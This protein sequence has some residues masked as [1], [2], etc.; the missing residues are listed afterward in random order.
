[1]EL[2]GYMYGVMK[3]L[4]VESSFG[5]SGSTNVGNFGEGTGYYVSA[6]GKISFGKVPEGFKY[7]EH[8]HV[9]YSGE[10]CPFC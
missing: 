1:K 3:N 10:K 2:D 9:S 5:C 6:D 4:T 7:C 8:C